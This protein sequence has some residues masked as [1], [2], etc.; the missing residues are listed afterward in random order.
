MAIVIPFQQLLERRQRELRRG[1]HQQCVKILECN[2]AF[3]ERM[4]EV[5]RGFEREVWQRRV[6]VLRAL[7]RHVERCP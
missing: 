6:D 1:L 4:Y 3:A 2:Y 5:S 7:L